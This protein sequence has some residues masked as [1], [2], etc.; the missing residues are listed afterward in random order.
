M[1]KQPEVQLR[2]EEL[3]QR[4]APSHFGGHHPGHGAPGQFP[5]GNPSDAPGNSNPTPPR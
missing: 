1:K 5:S 3:E 2:V 4:I